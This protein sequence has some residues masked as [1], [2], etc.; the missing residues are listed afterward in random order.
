MMKNRYIE[1]IKIGF[2]RL[3]DNA[4][5]VLSKT[6]VMKIRGRK[7][8]Y[9]PMS[10]AVVLISVLV[11]TAIISM[12]GSAGT[13][14][15]DLA[16]G[17]DYGYKTLQ[18]GSNIIAYCNRGMA[19]V[20]AK[21]GIEWRV[22]KEL[23]EPMAEA[24][25]SYILLADLAGNHFAASYKNG[26]LQNEYKLGSDIIS[27]KITKSGYAVFATDTD[28]YKGRVTVF[29]RRGKEIYVWNS[30]SG[31]I[32]DAAI[33]DN[34]RYIAVSQLVTGGGDTD[35]RIQIIDT[36]KGETVAS[37][38]RAGE[39]TAELKFLSPNRLIAVTDN[40]VAAYSRGG[41]QIFD[42]SL[43]G[44]NPSLYSLDSRDRLAVVTLDNRGN[45]LL[46]LY[47]YSG[48]LKAC[49]TASGDIRAMDVRG[50]T[51]VSV[52]QR[53]IVRVSA[54]GKGRSAVSVNHDIKN[55]GLFPGGKRALVIG[56]SQ[57]ECIS[58]R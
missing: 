31:Y 7:I 9:R 28:G 42:I 27:G 50:R 32:T 37:I 25:G 16:F 4:A 44:K 49:Y 38:D 45:N 52:E 55:I 5:A 23:S 18:S 46:E 13:K 29:N 24:G 17:T 15:V 30:G 14:S 54:R 22:E 57:S 36:G 20:N 39:V 35:T 1:R 34:G 19:A 51:A 40:H 33:T 41:K 6:A 2:M 48:K 26:K 3:K 53:G 47:S 43:S 11:L 10:L 8:V 12:L 58:V 21:G 56:T